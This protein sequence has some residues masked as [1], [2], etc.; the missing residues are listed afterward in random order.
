MILKDEC[1]H[2]R[3]WKNKTKKDK[4]RNKE[5]RK[6]RKGRHFCPMRSTQRVWI[7]R[8]TWVLGQWGL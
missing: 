8:K 4:K 3:R 2:I 6:K 7:F 1:S 5:K